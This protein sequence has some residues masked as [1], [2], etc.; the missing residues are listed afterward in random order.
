M[1]LILKRNSKCQCHIW[2]SCWWRFAHFLNLAP[3]STITNTTSSENLDA[4]E[5]PLFLIVNGHHNTMVCFSLNFQNPMKL[6]SNIKNLEFLNLIFWFL[7]AYGWRQLLNLKI[8]NLI[9]SKIL[10][11]IVEAF[12]NYF[13]KIKISKVPYMLPIWINQIFEWII[14]SIFFG[15]ILNIGA[16]VKISS[17]LNPKFGHI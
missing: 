15:T 8:L 10:K 11:L 3:D 7:K 9:L 14:S 16:S 1:W 5:H 12:Q 4:T 17:R 2:T 6:S 13:Y